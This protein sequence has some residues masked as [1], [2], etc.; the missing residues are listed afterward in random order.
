MVPSMIW[1]GQLSR[2]I[3]TSL[4]RRRDSVKNLASAANGSGVSAPSA[5]RLNVGH[6]REGKTHIDTDASIDMYFLR[7]MWNAMR[8]VQSPLQQKHTTAIPSS[9]PVPLGELYFP[10]I[11]SWYNQFFF[12]V[13]LLSAFS[14]D[15]TLVY[16][17]SVFSLECGKTPDISTTGTTSRQAFER[18]D[19]EH[20]E[21]D[22]ISS[23]GRWKRLVILSGPLAK[24]GLVKEIDG[25]NLAERIWQRWNKHRRREVT[26]NEL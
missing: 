21:M 8:C 3:W 11:L 6:W 1:F 24:L 26:K 22:V 23:S 7:Q 16:M 19:K 2:M 17:L 20:L 10:H 18:R 5:S 15:V 9:Q 13:L 4:C 12:C 25:G 14:T